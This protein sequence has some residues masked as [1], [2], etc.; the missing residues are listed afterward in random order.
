MLFQS[1]N[2]S[3]TWGIEY[4]RRTVTPLLNCD[5]IR[6]KEITIRFHTCMSEQLTAAGTM[7]SWTKVRVNYCGHQAPTRR[8]VVSSARPPPVVATPRSGF[9]FV[10]RRQ[11]ESTKLPVV[12]ASANNLPAFVN[13]GCIFQYPAR[14][15]PDH[16]VQ[17]LH[18]PVF[19]D[20]CVPL[21]SSS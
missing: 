1:A 4:L 15:I 18:L 21:I 12:N 10:A 3:E 19:P 6:R 16:I 8:I 20:K 13:I 11:Q 14:S 5:V 9:L 17:I 7:L 2:A